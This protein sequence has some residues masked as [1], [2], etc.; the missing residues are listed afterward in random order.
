VVAEEADRL[1]EIE[2]A[3]AMVSPNPH[4]ANGLCA[5][6]GTSKLRA[7]RQTS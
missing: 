3:S 5:A 7:G 2:A 6:Q 1:S 4:T